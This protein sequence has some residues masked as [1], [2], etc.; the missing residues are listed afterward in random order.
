MCR[1]TEG[2]YSCDCEDGYEGKLCEDID[3]CTSTA[4]CHLRA[5][6][7]NIEGNYTCHCKEG[8]FGN[9]YYCLRGECND[10]LCCFSSM[11]ITK[12]ACMKREKLCL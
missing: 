11:I 4:K 12:I 1:N 7:Q 3:E 9:G 10:R 5:E 8:Y 2:S 6:C